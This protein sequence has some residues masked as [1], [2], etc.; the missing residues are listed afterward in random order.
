[1]PE[2]VTLTIDGQT[3]S[4]LKGTLVVEAARQVQNLIPVFCYHP[5]MA[6]VGMCRMCVVKIGMPKVDRATNK[7][8]LDANGKP[9]IAM[10]PRLQTA[11]TT[12]VSEG[13]VVVTEDEEVKHAQNGV[14][15][16][17]LTSHPLDCPVCDKGGEC[18]LQNLTMGWGPGKTRFDYN[19][20]VH[21]EKPIPL[22]DLIYLDRE[23]CILCA[24]CVR[25]E[26][27]IAGDPVLG[28]DNRGRAWQ[29]ISK[30]DPVFDS[31]FS[32][33]TTDI[34]PVGALTSADFRFKARVWELEP[35]PTVCNHCPVGCDMTFD[36][37][38]NSIKRVMPREND[39]VNEIWICDRG[40]YAHHFVE[41]AARIT[42]P[43]V[44]K[45]GKLQDATW[46]EALEIV[47]RQ[48]DGIRSTAGGKA[49]GGLAGTSLANE[50]LYAFGRFFRETLGS[51][52]LDHRAGSVLD[53]PLDDVGAQFGLTAG[54]D[55][56]KLGKGTVVLVFG[57]DPEEEAPVHLLRIKGIHTR[58]GTIITAN[59]RTTKLD[60]WAAQKLQFRYGSEAAVLAAL[61][62]PFAD[63]VPADGKR[64]AL[65]GF[66]E[67][68]TALKGIT[69]ENSA[70]A[71][72]VAVESLQATNELLANAENLVIFY[73]R[74][75]LAAGPNVTGGLA[76]LLVLSR[77]A[78]AANSGV[79]AL[80][81][82]AN[83]RGA[84]DLGI[85]PDRGAGYVALPQAGLSAAQMLEAAQAGK[86]KALI[87][88]GVDPAGDNPASIAALKKVDLLVVHELF[89]TETA[90]LADVVL[91]VLTVAEREGTFTNAERRVQRFRQARR[92]I[93][94]ARPDWQIIQ[95]LALQLTA[96]AVLVTAGAGADRSRKQARREEGKART[97]SEWNYA[98]P[99]EIL[100]DISTSV[101]QYKNVTYATLQG[102]SGPWGRQT[103]ENY[104]FDG[105]SYENTGGVGI[106]IPAAV[107]SG[108]AALQPFKAVGRVD[109]A[110]RPLTLVG[111][112][113]LYDNGALL[114]DANLLNNRR[115][116]AQVC[117]HPTDADALGVQNGDRVTLASARGT[118]TLP[119]YRTRQTPS[120]V[121][122]VPLGVKG[123]PLV[124]VA[125]GAWTAVSLRR[126]EA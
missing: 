20:K 42:N 108:V 25:F 69:N 58:G 56:G 102:P 66:N 72:G 48:L 62:K 112:T 36:M 18:P 57:A 29:I 95:S 9:V 53:L 68:Q 104:Y 67:L 106:Q 38:S 70:S 49:I 64:A 113:F 92:S 115:A 79:V 59:G 87:V 76:N 31:K 5:K 98:S 30:S 122:V 54:T 71:A 74:D 39:A 47:V 7:P 61:L 90:K 121:V 105:T 93:N 101:P 82:G 124:E 1:M 125:E 45:N 24:R 109:H 120:G 3:V 17:L 123:V 85:R 52:N 33:N 40:R 65:R 22:G 111:A 116:K 12:P 8:E 77:K 15:E 89:M 13:M 10:M 14:L 80:V 50:D 81:P 118:M 43:M 110:D 34:C 75:A 63:A 78:G 117:L 99:A 60:Q 103:N 32:G 28:F 6:P 44:R 94:N 97:R 4:V 51:N 21:F 86:L 23:R 46:D 88:A 16:S 119:V 26:D 55:L 35:I 27:E 107:E 83:A 114:N 19:D 2:H 84:L 73:G 91:P 11:C 37:R 100:M 126:A 41:S 96:E